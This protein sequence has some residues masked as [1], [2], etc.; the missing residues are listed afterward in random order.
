ML[1]TE[2]SAALTLLEALGVGDPGFEMQAIRVILRHLAERQSAVAKAPT[3]DVLRL[4][5]LPEVVVE[6]VL[7]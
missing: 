6:W 2:A 1:H 3:V 5:G 7:S 4:L